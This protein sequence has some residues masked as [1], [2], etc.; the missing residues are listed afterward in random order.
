MSEKKFYTSKYYTYR[1]LGV[2]LLV[3][4][5]PLLEESIIDL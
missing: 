3:I 2:K 1:M 5:N 4:A